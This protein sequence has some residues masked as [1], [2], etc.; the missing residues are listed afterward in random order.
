[1]EPFAIYYGRILEMR[2]EMDLDHHQE[3][4]DIVGEKMSP[5]NSTIEI[6]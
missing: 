2:E 4:P 6:I 3:V 5:T 1:M